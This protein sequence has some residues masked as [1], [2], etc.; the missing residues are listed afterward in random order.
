[1]GFPLIPVVEYLNYLN[2]TRKRSNTVK[3]YRYALKQYFM[4][5]REK[6]KDYREIHLRRL[7]GVCPMVEEST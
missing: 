3:T 1:M 4:Y 6:K 2:T 5:L 7:D